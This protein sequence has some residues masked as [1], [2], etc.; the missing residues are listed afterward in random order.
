MNVSIVI[1]AYN[2]AETI[3]ETWTVFL[4]Q[5]WGRENWTLEQFYNPETVE[6]ASSYKK[7][8]KDG[9]LR[10]EVSEELPDVET[11]FPELDVLLTVGGVAIG[12]VSVPVEENF[13]SAQALRVALIKA[14]EIELCRACVREALLGRALDEPIPLLY[15][16]H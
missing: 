1:P 8:S 5:I 11:K 2:A 3:G 14:T 13:V 4:Q 7:N 9:S 12:C 16:K 15:A 6:E 10:V